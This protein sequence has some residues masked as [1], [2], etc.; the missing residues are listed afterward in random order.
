MALLFTEVAGS[1]EFRELCFTLQGQQT[2][3]FSP[4]DFEFHW[5]YVSHVWAYERGRQN[6]PSGWTEYYYCRLQNKKN[7]DTSGAG[8]QRLR[9]RPV[10]VEGLCSNKVRIHDYAVLCCI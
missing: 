1:E 5:P 3:Y 8:R 6:T 7:G 9:R 4:A 2:L 10:Y